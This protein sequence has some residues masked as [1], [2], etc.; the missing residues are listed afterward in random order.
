MGTLN[1]I[2]ENVFKNLG[3]EFYPTEMFS[4]KGL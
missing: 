3:V 1:G 4:E 2:L